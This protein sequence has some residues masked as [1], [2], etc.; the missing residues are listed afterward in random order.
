MSPKGTRLPSG[1]FLATPCVSPQVDIAT[2]E[3]SSVDLFSEPG[4]IADLDEDGVADWMIFIGAS[5]ITS[6]SAY[7]LRRGDC[8][9]FV[10]IVETSANVWP[11]SMRVG[12]V[13]E[14]SGRSRCQ[15]ECCPDGRVEFWS[16]NGSVYRLSRT[17]ALPPC[18]ARGPRSPAPP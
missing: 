17:K 1:G 12:G 16:F 13:L 15:V 6:R 14:L 5:N 4:D 18:E 7:Y 10:G 9:H 2:R 3:K 8:G 11:T